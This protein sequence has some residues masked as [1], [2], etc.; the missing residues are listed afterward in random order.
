ML[1]FIL[2]KISKI[3]SDIE[4]YRK[5]RWWAH[6][7]AKGMKLGKGVNLPFST[8]IDVAHCMLISIGDNCGFGDDCLILA[9]DAMPNEYLD[10]T[11]I[12]RVDIEES[13]HFGVRTIILPG[14]R[15][16]KG[17]VIGSNSVVATDIPPGSLAAGNPAK[18]ICTMEDY[19]E[20]HREAL[21]TAH[22]F[23][24]KKYAQQYLTPER[25]AEMVNK[26]KEGKGYMV[27]GYTAMQEEGECLVR[28]E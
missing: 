19:L 25:M 14:V 1:G 15:I 4:I 27:G 20:K 28:T 12:G 8:R 3:R 9:H 11:V 26:L 6:L 21:K 24:Y 18:V 13:C 23:E 2:N 7:K 10:A 22:K 17:S 16:G 5:K